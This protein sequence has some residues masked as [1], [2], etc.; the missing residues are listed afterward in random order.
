MGNKNSA[1]KD[2]GSST[3][4]FI[5][6]LLHEWKKNTERF[7][8]PNGAILAHYQGFLKQGVEYGDTFMEMLP[9]FIQTIT[10]S[11]MTFRDEVVNSLYLLVLF[12]QMMVHTKKELL[13]EISEEN[14]CEDLDE[15]QE[16]QQD[17]RQMIQET[18]TFLQILTDVLEV[19]EKMN[20]TSLAYPGEFTQEMV[21]DS[22]IEVYQHKMSESIQYIKKGAENIKT[23]HQEA[24]SFCDTLEQGCGQIK[25]FAALQEATINIPALSNKITASI[26]NI[27]TIRD[28]EKPVSDQDRLLVLQDI[29]TNLPNQLLEIATEK[30]KLLQAT[31]DIDISQPSTFLDHP[32]L[33]Q[34]RE[35]IPSDQQQL[36]IKI[37]NQNSVYKLIL[38]AENIQETAG[39][40]I[41]AISQPSG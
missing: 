36:Y 40:L 24:R 3:D 23:A 41:A 26:E 34:N 32:I 12:K 13:S 16:R 19:L 14:A 1:S 9:S 5:Q 30:R 27:I 38:M 28:S 20:Y 6:G 10:N 18:D 7:P 35:S 33:K 29:C 15:E 22:Q 37:A 25:M 17:N 4:D 21:E 39:S 2:T 11:G 8:S 31:Q